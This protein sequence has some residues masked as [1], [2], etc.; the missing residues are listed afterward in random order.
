MGN[1]E[2]Y[3]VSLPAIVL[4]DT[5]A[6]STVPGD[7]DDNDDDE[8]DDDNDDGDNDDESQNGMI[9]SPPQDLLGVG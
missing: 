2:N 3:F 6:R 8:D 9:V 7:D 4:T 1:H 5:G